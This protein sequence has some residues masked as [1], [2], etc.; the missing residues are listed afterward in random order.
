MLTCVYNLHAEYIMRN[1]RLNKS[2]AGIKIAGRNI[3]NLRYPRW[4]DSIKKKRHHFADKFPYGQSYHF[5]V[6]MYECD[7]WII[8]KAGCWRIDA[9]E[10]WY[11]RRLLK[12]PWT[13]RR[14]NQWILKEIWIFIGRTHAKA[15]TPVL[16]HLMW[17]ADFLEKALMLWKIKDR[18]R[19]GWQR[20]RW[21]DGIIN[22]MGVS[23]SKLQKMVN[24]REA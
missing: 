6:V 3:S 12:V 18:R 14:S 1:A 24:D 4:Y 23:L 2:Q 11:W 8:K 13:V 9:F 20:M 15:E 7:N 22:T 21:L 5:P 10:L 17:R 19:R 16:C